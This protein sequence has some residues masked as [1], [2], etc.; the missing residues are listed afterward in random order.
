MP[1][2]DATTGGARCTTRSPILPLRLAKATRLPWPM[3]SSRRM[4]FGIVTWRL[5][6][7][8]EASML[9]M[10][11]LRCKSSGVGEAVVHRPAAV[12]Q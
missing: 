10:A 5:L 4:A 3:P 2:P 7:T 9:R 6:V 1:K 11:V 8:V 12:V